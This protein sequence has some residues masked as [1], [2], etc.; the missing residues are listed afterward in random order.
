MTGMGADGT[1]GLQLMKEKGA[2]I[3][4]QDEST[5]VVFGMAKKSIEAG[6]VDV[7]VPLEK[8]AEQIQRTTVRR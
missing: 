7:V 6:I 4:A 2:T 3:I 1:K 8:M 5:S